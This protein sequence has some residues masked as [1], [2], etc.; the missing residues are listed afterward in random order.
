M[1]KDAGIIC[2]DVAGFDEAQAFCVALLDSNDPAEV[3]VSPCLLM[4][5]VRKLLAYNASVVG[6]VDAHFIFVS[7][8]AHCLFP[9]RRYLLAAIA[10]WLWWVS[11]V[12]GCMSWDA[13]VA[14]MV[15]VLKCYLSNEVVGATY[16]SLGAIS[17]E[18][19]GVFLVSLLF[20]AKAGIIPGL[21]R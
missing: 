1:W 14:G 6:Y 8:K 17:L 11:Y 7:P 4:P 5:D 10:L 9:R 21:C 20:V 16:L 2:F 19:F 15:L 18:W 13:S 3:R 12:R